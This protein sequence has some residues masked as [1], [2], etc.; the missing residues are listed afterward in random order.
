MIIYVYAKYVYMY[1]L[2]YMDICT[3]VCIYGY[4]YILWVTDAY[5]IIYIFVFHGHIT[6]SFAQALPD[7]QAWDGEE[8]CCPTPGAGIIDI[9]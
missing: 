9:H 8:L 3:Y 4:M 2:V 5:C 1:I 6:S 7:P